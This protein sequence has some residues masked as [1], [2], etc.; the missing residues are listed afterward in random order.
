MKKIL[1]LLTC[2]L[3]LSCSAKPSFT[4][5][6]ITGAKIGGNFSLLD[7]EKKPRT[8]NE[9][10]GKAVAVFF[11]FTHCPDVCPTA[12]A[13]YATVTKLLGDKGKDLQVIFI[14][15]DPQRDTPELV[16]KYAAA[17]N[18]SFLG[19]SGNASEIKAAA[20][21]FKAF[22]AVNVNSKAPANYSVDHTAASYVFDKQGNIRLYMKQGQ[23]VESMAKDIAQLL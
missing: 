16:S 4:A 10:K 12:L 18:P 14:T 23:S 8:L 21:L 15:V 19:L 6:D 7:G 5:T 2:A 13:E 1:L 22:Y 20:D 9:F 17:F 11:G 3:L